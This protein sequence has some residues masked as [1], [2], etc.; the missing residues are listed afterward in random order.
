MPM[1]RHY[2]QVSGDVSAALNRALSV[3]PSSPEPLQ[4]L[5]SLR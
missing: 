2:A 3:C 5:A 1:R 4:A